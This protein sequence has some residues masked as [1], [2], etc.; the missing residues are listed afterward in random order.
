[1]KLFVIRKLSP[2]SELFQA[3]YLVQKNYCVENLHTCFLNVLQIWKYINQ[4][5]FKEKQKLF[6]LNCLEEIWGLLGPLPPTHI[7]RIRGREEKEIYFTTS[8]MSLL[9]SAIQE[10]KFVM[11]ME[12][13]AFFAHFCP[14]AH[15]LHWG[16]LWGAKRFSFKIITHFRI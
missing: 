8:K 5:L 4:R 7:A 9:G 3:L 11:W 12:A 14:S 16:R 13:K 10:M 1:M 15:I 2:G 6:F